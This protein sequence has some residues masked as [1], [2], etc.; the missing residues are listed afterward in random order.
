MWTFRRNFKP[1][2]WVPKRLLTSSE[3]ISYWATRTTCSVVPCTKTSPF[4][5]TLRLKMLSRSLPPLTRSPI[6][7][8]WSSRPF[9]QPEGRCTRL[10]RLRPTRGM[11]RDNPLSSPLKEYLIYSRHSKRRALVLLF[12]WY[13]L[14][15]KLKYTSTHRPWWTL[16]RTH[17]SAACLAIIIFRTMHSAAECTSDRKSSHM[18]QFQRPTSAK[19]LDCQTRLIPSIS[20]SSYFLRWPRLTWLTMPSSFSISR[21]KP[22]ISTTCKTFKPS[23]CSE[24]SVS[25][26]VQR[27]LYRIW[28]W[29]LTAASQS[30][31]TRFRN[32]RIPW[33]RSERANWS[34]STRQSPPI[35]L[36]NQARKSLDHSEVQ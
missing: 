17:P 30:F 9:I 11:S 4:W 28:L 32:T 23:R 3:A 8:R 27:F 25:G 5:S 12:P 22:K 18:P 7:I 24:R 20:N 36:M 14:I 6:L 16:R 35:E 31:Q 26:S 19:K 2:T 15:M 21:C 13:H 1:T 29:S 33:S 34:Q 10:R